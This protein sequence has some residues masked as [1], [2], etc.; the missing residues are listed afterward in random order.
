[1]LEKENKFYVYEWIRLDTNTP[2]YVGKGY[3]NRF[4]K[5]CQRNQYFKNIHSLVKTEVKI[6]VS[7]LTEK[8]AFE[9]EKEF[10]S[11]YKNLGYC[12][13]NFTDG[14]EGASGRAFSEESKIKLSKSSLG[15]TMSKE[16]KLKMSQAKKLKSP[17]NKGL[18]YS[19]EKIDTMMSKRKVP[20]PS[21][22]GKS[23]SQNTK[24][25]ISISNGA[26]PFLVFK[27]DCL[28][29]EWINRAECGRFLNINPKR[30]VECLKNRSKQYK[31]YKFKHKE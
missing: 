8:E 24:L 14:G 18:K 5:T 25:L 6:L 15:K 28:I 23:F 11:L 2:F 1:M 19:K 29:G 4:K 9:K 3:G 17:P 13:A 30:I 27:D 21:N 12:E 26:K 20:L 22:L 31:G 7:N 10:I 16:A